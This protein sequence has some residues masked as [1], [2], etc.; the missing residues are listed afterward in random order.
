MSSRAPSVPAMMSSRLLSGRGRATLG[1]RLATMAVLAGRLRISPSASSSRR[2]WR[3]VI[4]LMPK[5]WANSASVGSASPSASVVP[6]AA[7]NASAA[8]R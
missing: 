3:T 2:A 7:R 8:W 4:R 6:I 5:P 1:V